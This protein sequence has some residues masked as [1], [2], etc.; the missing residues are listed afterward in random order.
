MTQLLIIQS[1]LESGSG[2]EVMDASM[3]DVLDRPDALAFLVARSI[4]SCHAISLQTQLDGLD[5][6]PLSCLFQLLFL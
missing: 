5:F 1:T 2:I 4:I 6:L 3:K